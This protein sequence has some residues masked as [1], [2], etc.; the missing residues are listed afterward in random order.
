MNKR[1]KKQ[2]RKKKNP[3]LII[4]LLVLAA[5]FVSVL[6]VIGTSGCQKQAPSG[7]NVTQNESQQQ[8]VVEPQPGPNEVI[9]KDLKFYPS[10][11]TIS[12]GSKVTFI[13]E[14]LIEHT[15]TSEMTSMYFDYKIQPG[16]SAIQYFNIPGT[17]NYH[18]SIHPSMNGKIIVE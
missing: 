9:I 12:K 3:F 2:Q 11:L 1:K 15:V 17:Y 16:M 14:D 4:V 5:L 18:C 6:L 10:E 8:V 7:Q 13:N